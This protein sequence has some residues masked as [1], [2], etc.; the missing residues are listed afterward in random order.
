MKSLKLFFL[1]SY[2]NN[3]TSIDLLA[4]QIVPKIAHHR[5]G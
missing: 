4:E 5:L 3:A 1:S 2:Y